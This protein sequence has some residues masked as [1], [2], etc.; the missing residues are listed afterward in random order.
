[1]KNNFLGLRNFIEGSFP[2]F[3]GNIYGEVYP[4]PAHAQFIAQL[5]GYLWLI[6]IVLLLGGDKI[7]Q[8]L[9]METPE[10]VKEMIKNKPGAFLA[11][12]IMNSVGNSMV[13]TGAFEI[14]VN[15]D[16]IFSKLQT[17]RFPTGD[18]LVTALEA[19]GYKM[20]S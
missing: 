2:E 10:F 18:E 4:P 6:G 8:A 14:F 3:Q 13:N 12:F 16:L 1:M 9:G 15:D 11:L 17:Q 5:T 19:M 20:S 7:F